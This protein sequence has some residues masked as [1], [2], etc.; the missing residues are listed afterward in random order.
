MQLIPQNE[1]DISPIMN[2]HNQ[3]YMGEASIDLTLR[4]CEPQTLHDNCDPPVV[5]E[6]KTVDLRARK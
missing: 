6:H 1:A 2:H 3:L 5:T 4:P